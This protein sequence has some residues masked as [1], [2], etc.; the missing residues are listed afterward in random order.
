[1]TTKKDVKEWDDKLHTLAERYGKS[2]LTE[3]LE[4]YTNFKEEILAGCSLGRYATGC[5]MSD[6]IIDSFGG[7]ETLATLFAKMHV[8]D[9]L[10]RGIIEEGD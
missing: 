6:A 2:D 9:V 1:M 3:W 5:Q 10:I 8:L 4:E 7:Y